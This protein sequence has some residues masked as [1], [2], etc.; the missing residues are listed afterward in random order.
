[1]SKDYEY[2]KKAGFD[3]E[4]LEKLDAGMELKGYEVKAVKSG[5]MNLEG[6]YVIIRGGEAFL[7]NASIA[8][9]QPKNI[10]GGYDASRT[11]RLLLTKK[12]LKYLTGKSQEKGL[13]LVPIRCYDRKNFVK[14][15]FAIARKK[16]K[17]DKRETIKNRETKRKI[18]QALKS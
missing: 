11:R 16:K 13:T 6:S 1:M 7:I 4:F 5:R 3:Y 17:H 15:E 8:A 12:E 9:L 18:D 14:L 10:P 2:N